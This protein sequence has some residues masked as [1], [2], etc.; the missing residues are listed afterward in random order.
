[1]GSMI[2]KMCGA[3]MNHHADKLMHGE[4]SHATVEQIIEAHSCPGCGYNDSRIAAE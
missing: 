3:E 1:M 4:G 2:C